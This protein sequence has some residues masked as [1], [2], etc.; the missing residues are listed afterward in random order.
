MAREVGQSVTEATVDDSLQVAAEKALSPQRW[1][2][3]REVWQRVGI[4]SHITMRQTLRQMA[5]AGAIE[6][7]LGGTADHPVR[8]YRRCR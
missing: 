5:D 2:T 1:M 6:G 8:E 3:A 4:G 7:R